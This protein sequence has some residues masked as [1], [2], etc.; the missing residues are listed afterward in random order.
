M[1]SVPHESANIEYGSPQCEFVGLYC[2]SL[3]GLLERTSKT[4]A[5]ATPTLPVDLVG[6]VA[7]HTRYISLERESNHY[8]ISMWFNLNYEL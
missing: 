2:H 1:T 7:T 5:T 4:T 8:T 6:G 3:C